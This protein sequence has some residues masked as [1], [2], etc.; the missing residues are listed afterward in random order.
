MFIHKQLVINKSH[1]AGHYGNNSLFPLNPS[2]YL[3]TL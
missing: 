3:A 1:T 2:T